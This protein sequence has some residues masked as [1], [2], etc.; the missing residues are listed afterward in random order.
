MS[1]P[2]H[3]AE[4]DAG[5]TDE[6]ASSVLFWEAAQKRPK[7]DTR[8]EDLVARLTKPQREDRVRELMREADHIY[9]RAIDQHVLRDRRALAASVL[10]FS[11]GNDS[12][13]LAHL[14]KDRATHAGHANTTIGIEKTREFVRNVCEEWGMPL[15]ERTSKDEKDSYRALVLDQGFPG[16]GHHFKMFQRL[17][18]RAI[19]QMQRELIENPY[20]QRVVYLAGRRRSESQRRQGIPE[21]ERNRSKVWV[22]P[23]VNWT[24]LDLTT[25]RT[26][27]AAEGDPVPVNEVSDLIH[28]SGE[29]L[30]GS[31][32]S[33]GERAEITYWFPEFGEVIAELEALIANRDDIPEHRK[34]WGW[35][36]DP[37]VLKASRTKASKVGALC[38][39]CDDRFQG[40][41][42]GLESA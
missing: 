13:V 24:K 26:M 30:C 21:A 20:R 31:F 25:Y 27:Q 22:S 12:T 16:P 17:K 42:P 8:I 28:M 35:G 7:P 32:A 4:S 18:E 34:K 36:A 19:D 37:A 39:S 5:L 9:L 15:L 6:D 23:L 1:E 11:G 29:C 33:P 40:V 10:L 3:T 41:L 14:F 38:S 2:L